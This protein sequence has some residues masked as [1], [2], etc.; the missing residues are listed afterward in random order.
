M[1]ASLGKKLAFSF[2]A[3]A[4][5]LTVSRGL[6][7]E[8]APTPTPTAESVPQKA[9]PEPPIEVFPFAIPY[10]V[11]KGVTYPIYKLGH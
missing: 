10:Y 2:C 5:V 4:A 1:A 3:L 9:L 6:H 7:A 11:L 8:P